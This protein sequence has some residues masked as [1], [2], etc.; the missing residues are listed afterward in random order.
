MGDSHSTPLKHSTTTQ[1]DAASNANAAGGL[2]NPAPHLPTRATPL[3]TATT[4]T[5]ITASGGQTKLAVEGADLRAA[6]AYQRGHT[7]LRRR[8]RTTHWWVIDPRG[9]KWLGIWDLVTSVALVFTALVTPYEAGFVPPVPYPGRLSDPLFIINRV[10]DGIFIFD[11]ILQ[12]CIGFQGSESRQELGAHWVFDPG[13]IAKRYV[14]SHWFY[15]DTFSITTSVFDVLDSDST[16]QLTALRALRAMRLVKIVRVLRGSRIFKRWEMRL[17]IDYAALSICTTIGQILVACHWFACIWGLQA[18]LGNKL[19]SWLGVNELCFEWGHDNMTMAQAEAVGCEPHHSCEMGAC[20]DGVCAAGVQCAAPG[21]LYLTALYW[22]AMTVSSVGY[23]DILATPG[24]Q[25]EHLVATFIM[26]GG[27]ILWGQ[28]IGTFCGVF[29]QLNPSLRAFRDDL[30]QL[31]VFMAR[32]GLPSEMRFRLR[33]YMFESVHVRDATSSVR[34]LEQISPVMRGEVQYMFGKPWLRRVWFLEHAELEMLI[35]LSSLLR[36]VVLPPGEMAPAGIMYM[37]GKGIGL[38]SGKVKTTGSVWGEDI[39]LDSGLQIA[40]TAV[41]ITYMWAYTLTTQDLQAATARASA[42]TQIALHRCRIRWLARRGFV[43]YAEREK[44][45]RSGDRLVINEGWASSAT[46]ST[47]KPATDAGATVPSATVTVTEPM[48]DQESL[49]RAARRHGLRVF[50]TEQFK[51]AHLPSGGGDDD[52]KGK[53]NES[54]QKKD[55]KEMAM[56]R[57]DV[58]SLQADVREILNLLQSKYTA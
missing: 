49:A 11:V 30:S 45:R 1:S 52:G 46:S 31:N 26:L 3:A 54:R 9:N 24:N 27:G 15:I 13:A 50:T 12:F 44:H 48:G 7:M 57:A 36:A 56:L 43:Q 19:D 33:E 42:D 5:A 53:G 10:I 29:S 32:M 55:A 8:I 22:S 35:D 20:T 41:A 38:W 16:Q 21:L 14:T 6:A 17:T 23:G 2:T 18:T 47:D 34:I 25:L 58:T 37:V 40:H 28:L 39:L 51:E 4:V